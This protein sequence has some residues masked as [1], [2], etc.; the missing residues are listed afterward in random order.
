MSGLLKHYS[1]LMNVIITFKK[2]M[3]GIFIA[4]SALLVMLDDSETSQT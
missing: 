4:T 1:S 3:K 2:V